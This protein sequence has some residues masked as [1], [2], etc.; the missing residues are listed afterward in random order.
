M[1]NL[2]DLLVKIP[3]Y[4]WYHCIQLTKDVWAN[5]NFGHS[6]PATREVLR[7]CDIKG[8]DVLDIGAM[9]GFFSILSWRRGAK[10]IIATDRWDNTDKISIVKHFTGAQFDYAPTTST[11]DLRDKVLA[12]W[13]NLADVVIFSGVL[14]HTLDPTGILI[15]VRDVAKKNGIVI[16]ETLAIASDEAKLFYNNGWIY[17]AGTYYIPTTGWLGF[18]LPFLGLS[19]VDCRY[20][21]VES[22]K[23]DLPTIR[24]A[25]VCRAVDIPAIT[26][27]LPNYATGSMAWY[28][29][30]AKR[31]F[32]E[33]LKIP[34]DTSESQVGYKSQTGL[35]KDASGNSI[36]LSSFWKK[37]DFIVDHSHYKL[38]LD[39]T[40]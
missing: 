30:D 32:G 1:K 7:L 22:G 19:P 37:K 11:L 17:N 6:T 27:P 3:T 26:P 20:F 9:E 25:L 8:A 33:Y 39:E 40:F 21:K 4:S 16:V 10:R 5:S 36:S 12:K 34:L 35:T 31:D 24:I 29:N 23:K 15:R 28:A 38:G 14:Y 13:E 18:M 2:D